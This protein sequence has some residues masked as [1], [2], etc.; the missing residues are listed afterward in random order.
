MK[1]VW[2][3]FHQEGIDAFRAVL[4]AGHD[5]AAAFTLTQAA[6]GKR[7]GVTDYAPICREYGVPLHHVSN[8]NDD[9]AMERLEA[10][11]PDL[12]VVL[13]WSQILQP[14]LLR[15]P[16]VGVVGAHASLLPH[17]RGRAP[18][19]WALIRGEEETGNTLMWLAEGVDTG[20]IIDQVAF[21]ITPFDTCATLYDHVAASNRAMVLRLLERLARSEKP[22]RPQPHT[23]EPAL[24]GRKPA[25]GLI[26]WSQPAQRVYDLVRGVTR[27]YPGAFTYL[28]GRKWI[29][30]SAALLPVELAPRATGRAGAAATEPSGGEARVTPPAWADPGEVL[31]M[32]VSPEPGACGPVVACADGALLLNELEDDAGNVLRGPDLARQPWRGKVF[33][34]G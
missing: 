25:D 6:A 33:R 8:I 9:S 32:A 5:V 34:D 28:D 11:A 18:V 20:A 23:D 15:L 29:V 16:R 13:G 24:P 27:P 26:D 7:S 22:G 12:I 4:E 2:V 31:G 10:L 17:N 3:G 1:I 19:N 14:R 30:W 21:P